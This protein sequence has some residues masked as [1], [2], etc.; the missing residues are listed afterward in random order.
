[1][2]LVDVESRGAMQLLMVSIDRPSC[3]E[4]SSNAAKESLKE[5]FLQTTSG[6][7]RCCRHL[8]CRRSSLDRRWLHNTKKLFRQNIHTN[9]FHGRNVS[10]KYVWS[11]TAMVWKTITR[12]KGK[13][14][15]TTHQ[16]VYLLFPVRQDI[17][18]A[19]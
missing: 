6:R 12:C 19:A 16:N 4:P 10:E 8:C 17:I 7:D 13:I 11:T 9:T 1:M 15:Q 3:G 14:K 18:R 5:R 2:P